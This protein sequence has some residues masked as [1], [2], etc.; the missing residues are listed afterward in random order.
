MQKIL[1]LTES[2]F[3][4]RQVNADSVLITEYTEDLPSCIYHTSLGDLSVDTIIK[5]SSQFDVIEFAQQGFDTSSD[6][7]KETLLL[8][9]YLTKQHKKT[10]KSVLQFTDHP[11][12]DTRSDQPILWVFGCSHSHGVGLLPHEL[13]YGKLLSQDLNLPLKLITKPGSSLHWSY[14]H[15]MNSCIQSQD[16]VIWQL[17]TPGRVSQFNGLN[18]EEIV[19]SNSKNR[20]LI[21]YMSDNQLYF[22]HLSLLNTGVRFLRSI[23]CKF[24]ITAICDFGRMYDYVFEYV[25][26]PEYCYSYGMQIDH[27]TDG[28]HVG[29]LSH[30]AIAQCLLNHLQLYND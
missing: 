4:F 20:K 24:A 14:R 30:K 3:D 11:G 26:Y 18:V 8:Y 5:L 22:N 27:G 1:Y 10:G 16:T 15:L 21:D 25:K 6:V 9:Q 7:Y 19:L 28:M 29:P 13:P 17:T 2:T 12:I 23:G